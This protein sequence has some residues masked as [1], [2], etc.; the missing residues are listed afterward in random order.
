MLN[1]DLFHG[2]VY[3]SAEL[4]ANSWNP[5]RLNSRNVVQE[6]QMDRQMDRQKDGQMHRQMHGTMIIPIG[7]DG[8]QR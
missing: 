7:A 8:S 5:E 1:R 2:T 4:Q 3:Q 6:E